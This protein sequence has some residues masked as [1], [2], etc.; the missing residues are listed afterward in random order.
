MVGV[1]RAASE[2]DA[3]RRLAQLCGGLPLAVCVAGARLASHP[4]RTIAQIAGELASE[5]DRLAALSLTED[6]SVRAAFDISYRALPAEAARAY[7]LLSLVPGPEFGLDLAAAAT[8]ADPGVTEDL[9][10]ALSGASLLQETEEA[11]FRFH[12]LVRLHAREQAD[13]EPLGERRAVMTRC[14]DWYLR[15]AVAAD[16]VVIPGRWR[17][18]PMYEQ[19]RNSPPA[20]GGPAEA[21][22]WLESELP[23]L[24]AAVQAAH[25]EG[26]HDQA[27]QLC[28]AL[29]G[30]FLYRM[31]F[32]PW[33]ET[34]AVGIAAARACGNRR[35]E[36]RMRDQLGYAYL[37]LSRFAEA[38]EQL[39]QA[40]EMDQQEGHRVGEATALEHLGQADLGLSR[41]DEAI[42]R[43][44]RARD[45][46][47][48]IGRPRGIALMT[49][50][51][52]EAHRDAG[53]HQEAIRHLME[54]R[55]LFA[56][57]PDR[58]NETRA[59]T[60]LAQ[61]Y[62][63]AGQPG[64]AIALLDEALA[65]MR[66]LGSDYEQARIHASLADAAE[67][68]GLPGKAR[69]H[70][71][72]ALVIYGEVGAPEAEEM[73]RRLGELGPADSR[74]PREEPS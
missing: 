41:P 19:A 6:L 29:W 68:L 3:A 63:G 9:L 58:F 45:I 27:W 62:L 32:R 24:R 11:R 39:T 42:P 73:R 56:A 5:R 50:R 72:Q 47:R 55:R 13:T 23:G 33:I 54:A 37:S 43:F 14:V 28:E 18:N 70:L 1:D 46:H 60:S 59:L 17:L 66:S 12:D 74:E 4:R 10:E 57:L 8:A 64:D 2:P 53:R 69:G 35:A 22:D 26:L 31:Y 20:Y 52:G 15:S 36:A 61:A 25:D 16:I 40:L 44:T 34:H 38:Q 71:E 30:L 21:L 65:T 7:R 48:Q 49:C 51:I 67:R